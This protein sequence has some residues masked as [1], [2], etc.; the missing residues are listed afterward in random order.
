MY[1]AR[2][3][4]PL[5]FRLD[6]E[7]A[8]ELSL[9]AAEQGR[10]GDRRACPGPRTATAGWSSSCF[11]LRFPNP[12][13]LAAGFDKRARAVPAWPA[14]GFGF[15]EIGTVTALGQPGNP[16]PRIHRLAADRAL[17]NRLGF[18]NDGAEAHGPAAGLVGRAAGLLHA[19][20]AGREPRPVAG[21]PV[22][23]SG[24]P[25]TPPASPACG[26]YADYVA[27]NVSSPNTPGLRD[28][29]GTGPARRDPG[30][31]GRGQPRHDRAAAA[32]RRLARAGE[33][34]ARPLGRAGRRGRRP[35]ARPRPGRRDRLQH[36]PLARGPPLA[37]R[38][39]R[40]ARA[41]CRAR[42][43][44]S[45]PP[46]SCA[47]SP[48]GPAGGWW[49]WA[50][51]ACST[52]TTPGRSWPPARRWCRCTPASCTAGPAR[53]ASIAAGLLARMD[54]EGVAAH[55]RDR[56]ERPDRRPVVSGRLRPLD[57]GRL[58]SSSAISPS[59]W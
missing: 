37:A 47:A 56:G 27:I 18:N 52:P 48:S 57:R 29:Q 10:A 5:L 25:T 44:A 50:W 39:H 41:A 36:H 45:A 23:A 40:A 26:R 22:R 38:A 33:A 31:R 1:A 51:G 9:G 17:I 20:P 54:R 2:P 15:A 30:R 6:P 7:R 53:R 19:R 14:L 21:R 4:R 35:R 55:R 8:H 24:R 46:P 3:R 58:C 42:R 28:L 16:R 59:S 12:I 13:G 43:C 34:G 11:G 32:R 49:W